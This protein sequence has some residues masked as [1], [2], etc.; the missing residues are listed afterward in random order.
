MVRIIGS[1]LL[2]GPF[3]SRPVR[4]QHPL[5]DNQCCAAISHLQHEAQIPNCADR[6]WRDFRTCQASS[7]V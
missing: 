5:V 1:A 4:D 7:A 2:G 3:G 6:A